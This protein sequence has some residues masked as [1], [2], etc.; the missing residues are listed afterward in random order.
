MINPEEQCFI[1]IQLN[2][3]MEGVTTDLS[4][5]HPIFVSEPVQTSVWPIVPA[6]S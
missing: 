3:L 1:R 4:H 2:L 6:M 5:G